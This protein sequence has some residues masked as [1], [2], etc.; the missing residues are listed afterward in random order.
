MA[1]KA[2]IHWRAL[3]GT[4]EFGQVQAAGWRAGSPQNLIFLFLST[5]FPPK[6]RFPGL[7]A[8]NEP[9]V[10]PS[11]CGVCSALGL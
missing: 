2:A 4:S 5:C 7:P 1:L 9:V 6:A 10:G 11:C 3:Q 8:K